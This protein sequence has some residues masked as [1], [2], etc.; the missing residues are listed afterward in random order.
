MEEAKTCACGTAMNAEN[1]CEHG[2]KCKMCCA[3]MPAEGS[4]TPAAQ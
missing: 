3:P 2:D 4:D 1:T